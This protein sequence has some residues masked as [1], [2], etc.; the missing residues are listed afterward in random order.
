MPSELPFEGDRYARQFACDGY[1]IREGV[2]SDVEVEH[3]RTAVACI[4]DGEEVR[5]RRGVYGVRNLLEICPAVEELARQTHI[6]QFVTPVLGDSAFAVRA[7]FFD[8]VPGSNWSLFWHQDN[9]ISISARVDVAGYIGWSNKAGVWQVQPPAQILANIVAVRVHLDD[10]GLEN[11]PLRVL[12]G[13]H[14]FGWLDDQL[15]D[16]KKRVPEVVCEVRRGGIVTMC[17]LL[18]HASARSTAAGHRRVIHIEY[19]CDE[20]P[21]GLEWNNLVGGLKVR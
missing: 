21:E 15:D 3:L 5:R 7:I 17:P 6:R 8:K 2:I 1:F 12:P 10:C 18:L 20:L 4:P 14:R 9:V 16:W 11:G 19:A 13:S